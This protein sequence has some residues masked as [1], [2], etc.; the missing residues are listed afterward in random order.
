MLA[1][2]APFCFLNPTLRQ[3]VVSTF[4]T[5]WFVAMIFFSKDGV[6]GRGT[7]RIIADNTQHQSSPPALFKGIGVCFETTP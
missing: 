4:G 3:S 5:H 1:H 7:A 2:L 6:W